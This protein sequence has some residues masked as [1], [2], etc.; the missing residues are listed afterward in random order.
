MICTSKW[1]MPRTPLAGL[2]H[3]RKR[4]GQHLV[5][6]LALGQALAELG[7]LPAQLFVGEGDHRRFECVDGDGGLAQPSDL[8]LVPVKQ[9]LQK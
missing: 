1:R 6:R 4:F 7:G 2:A 9:A 3:D 8:S 5:E